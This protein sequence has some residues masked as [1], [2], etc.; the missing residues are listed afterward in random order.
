MFS[1]RIRSACPEPERQ[2]C[3]GALQ[4]FPLAAV[5]VQAGELCGE[6]LEPGAPSHLRCPGIPDSPAP[7]PAGVLVIEGPSEGGGEHA[8]Q[9]GALAGVGRRPQ[10]LTSR[11]KWCLGRKLAVSGPVMISRTALT[12]ADT[13]AASLKDRLPRRRIDALQRLAEVLLG[14][15]QAESTLHRK[16]ALHHM[17]LVQAQSPHTAPRPPT[18]ARAGVVALDLQQL[19]ARRGREEAAQVV[20]SPLTGRV[21]EGWIRDATQAGVSVDIVIVSEVSVNDKG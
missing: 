6:D 2:Q 19:Q 15:L 17:G 9:G 10:Q 13:L 20:R 5:G 8:D 4:P 7:E 3:A 11:D 16:I 1:T 18:R 12:H 14:S 21:A